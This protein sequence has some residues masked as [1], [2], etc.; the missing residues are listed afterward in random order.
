MWSALQR[1]I[2]HFLTTLCCPVRRDQIEIKKLVYTIYMQ[3]INANTEME[4][5]RITH[6]TQF[7]QENTWIHI[8]NLQF[9]IKTLQNYIKKNAIT[10]SRSHGSVRESVV[11]TT[12]KVN[13]KCWNLTSRQPMNPFSNRHHIWRACHGY[14]PPEKFGLNPLRG[15]FSPYSLGEICTP[16]FA[17]L[18]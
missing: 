12:R 17:T 7:T 14:L 1:Q 15:F 18:R 8:E 16:M 6:A 2:M 4:I 5:S 11:S 10:R 3:L 9:Y 13:G